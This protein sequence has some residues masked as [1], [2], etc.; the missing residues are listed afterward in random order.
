[1][2]NAIWLFL[3]TPVWY[4]SALATL[5]VP[6]DRIFGLVALVG[7]L[8][9]V[10]GTVLGIKRRQAKL[11]WFLLSPLLS[12]VY[13]AFAG[14]LRGALASDPAT[15]AFWIFM[16]LQLAMLSFL[17]FRCR[18]ARLPGAALSLFGISYAL[19]AAFFAAMSFTDTWL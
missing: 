15:L 9:L 18:D 12:Q 3:A 1:M 17:L 11:L 10:L 8:G 2:G 7:L 13:V 6:G 14:L 19:F 4:L 5:L 16:A